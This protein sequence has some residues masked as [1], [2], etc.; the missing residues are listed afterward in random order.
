MAVAIEHIGS[1]AVD[2]LAAKLIIDID[3]LRATETGLYAAVDRLA[4]VGYVHQGKSPR[5][6]C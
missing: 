5:C 4:L 1:T 3:V 6:P 2:G